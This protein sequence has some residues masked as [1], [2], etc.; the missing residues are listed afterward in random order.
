MDTT[1]NNDKLQ[2]LQMLKQEKQV[3]E[4]KLSM[5]DIWAYPL[6]LIIFFYVFNIISSVIVNRI[7]GVILIISIPF[8][9]YSVVKDVK[10]RWAIDDIEREIKRIEKQYS[11]EIEQLR[12]CVK[13]S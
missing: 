2:K 6:R 4:K 5:V 10:L 9:G 7:F 1:E 12:D 11:N 13:N 8:V 3:L